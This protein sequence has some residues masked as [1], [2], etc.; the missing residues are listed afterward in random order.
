MEEGKRESSGLIV[1]LPEAI[2]TGSLKWGPRRKSG[3]GS[4]GDGRVEGAFRKGEKRDQSKEEERGE[5]TS[6]REV[7]VVEG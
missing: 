2:S 4:E 3:W 1:P 5:R 7:A 6:E